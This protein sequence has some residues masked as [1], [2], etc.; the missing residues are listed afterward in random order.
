[1]EITLKALVI[2]NEER[3]YDMGKNTGMIIAKHVF[4]NKKNE[5][6]PVWKV[7]G[8]VP[9]ACGI[10]IAA[11][12]RTFSQTTVVDNVGKM[13]KEQGIGPNDTIIFKNSAGGWSSASVNLIKNVGD[14]FDPKTEIVGFGGAPIQKSPPA[15]WKF[16]R[17]DPIT[18]T[19]KAGKTISGQYFGVKQYNTL[20]YTSGADR[21]SIPLS[22]VTD[23][24]RA[25]PVK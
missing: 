1:L 6:R 13:V 3:R 8:I 25:G 17:G 20:Y 7:L 5:I 24:A 11:S 10:V 2:G 12:T 19:T 21:M 18:I 22:D 23:I 16:K 9:L 4:I 14:D 15:V